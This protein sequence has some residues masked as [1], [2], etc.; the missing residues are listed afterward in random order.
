MK[1]IS[2]VLIGGLLLSA[3]LP[4]CEKQ[5]L[6]EL[7]APNCMLPFADSSLSNPKN[8]KYRHLLDLYTRKGLPGLVVLIRTPDE[9]LWIGS[10][11]YARIEDK[12]P[13]RPCHILYSASVGKTYCAVATMRMQEQGLLSLDDPISKFL[14]PTIVKQLANGNSL[15]V[16]HLI[17]HTSGLPNFDYNPS[18]IAVFLNN[19]FGISTGDLIECEF[20]KK[21][22]SSPGEEFHY[23]STGYEL[24]ALVLDGASGRHHS[25][26]YTSELFR[27]LRL[28]NTYYKQELGYPTPD[29]VVNGYFDR[30]GNGRLENISDQNNYMTQIF[31]GSDGVM[32]SAYDYMLFF[33]AVLKGKLL[34]DNSIQQMQTWTFVSEKSEGGYGLFRRKTNHGV[35]I[36][37]SGRSVGAGIDVYYFP[38]TDVTILTAVN[39]GTFLQTPLV[40][41]YE[42]ELQDELMEVVF[43]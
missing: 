7:V 28:N 20:G 8:N 37:H 14:P 11:G 16:R 30:L 3:L 17:S 34:N 24:L 41:I 38:D 2:L 10:A 18:F 27:P 23:S 40:S 39:L 21:E 29:G 43:K 13:M 9:G 19:P 33:E 12:T 26:Y 5:E 1:R 35:K 32:A 25:S 36:G 4:G 42:N 22:L 6:N 15:T 31:T